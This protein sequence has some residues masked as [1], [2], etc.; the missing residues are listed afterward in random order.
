MRKYTVGIISGA[1]IALRAIAQEIDNHDRFELKAF[2]TRS[3][4]QQKAIKK[5][6][7]C[8]VY[9]G[10]DYLIKDD[11][12]DFVYIPLPNS[13][14]KEWVL[15]AINAGKHVLC[16]KSLGCYL[17]DVTEMVE[18]AEQNNC[19]LIENFQFRFHSQQATVKKLISENEIGEVQCF[20]ST[21]GFP[22]FPDSN[23]IRYKRELGGG[24]LLDAGAYTLRAMSF[25]MGSGFSVK[26][27]AMNT[28]SGYAV[29]ITG[30]IFATNSKG[31]VAQ[32]AYGFNNFYQCNY[33]VWGTKGKITVLRAFTSPPGFSPTI[34]IEKQGER[35]ERV[36]SPDNHYGNMLT[37]CAKCI[38]T[39]SFTDEYKQL[40]EQAELI[41]QTKE[42][43]N[44]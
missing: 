16:E 9:I 24:A 1:N 17:A 23:N 31:V 35:E 11:D 33:E 14:H 34:I 22:P 21:F 42:K 20:R 6:F 18:A 43:S 3:E 37:H 32:L 40:I 36:L 15:K 2:A 28:P 13:L 27:A 7:N 8:A 12:I 4:D 29:D 19:L 30:G 5:K 25:V 10:Y 44:E 38:D 41:E 26:S 39:S